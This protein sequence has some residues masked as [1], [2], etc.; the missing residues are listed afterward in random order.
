MN[1]PL[2][3]PQG[4]GKHLKGWVWEMTPHACRVGIEYHCVAPHC[5]DEGNVATFPRVGDT[6]TSLAPSPE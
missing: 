3:S 5:V 6:L 2:Y 4:S 1:M